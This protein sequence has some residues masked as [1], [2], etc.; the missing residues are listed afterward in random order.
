MISQP[1]AEYRSNPHRENVFAPRYVEE[2]AHYNYVRIGPD[3]LRNQICNLYEVDVG[4]LNCDSPSSRNVPFKLLKVVFPVP[5]N[6]LDDFSADAEDV[7]TVNAVTPSPSTRN[8]PPKRSFES[9]GDSR[10]S[11][12]SQ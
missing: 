6:L 3:V 8:P 10:G 2:V 12:H 5:K 7:D 11:P 9:I 1:N 4:D